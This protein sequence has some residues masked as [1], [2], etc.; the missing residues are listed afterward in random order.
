MTFMK[1]IELIDRDVQGTRVKIYIYHL[2]PCSP[3]LNIS[4]MKNGWSLK[5]EVLA[6]ITFFPCSCSLFKAF[7]KLNNFDYDREGSPNSNEG[8]KN[9]PLMIV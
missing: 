6:E 4:T 9:G 5:T 2:K 7:S 3:A 8:M 1:I